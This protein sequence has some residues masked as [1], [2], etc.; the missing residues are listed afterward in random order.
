MGKAVKVTWSREAIFRDL[1]P[2]YHTTEGVI[3]NGEI[4]ALNRMAGQNNDHC[5]AIKPNQTGVYGRISKPYYDRI[6]HC[7]AV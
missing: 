5:A 1:S 6:Q 3:K 4:S 7:H 2:G